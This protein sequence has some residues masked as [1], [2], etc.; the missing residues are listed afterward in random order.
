MTVEVLVSTPRFGTPEF[1]QKKSG[2]KTAS[3][4]AGV[5]PASKPLQTSFFKNDGRKKLKAGDV[6]FSQG[7]PGGDLYFIEEGIV[8]IYQG[9]DTEPVHLSDMKAG[10]II[11]VITCLTREPRMATARAKTSVIC[12]Q[13]PHEAIKKVLQELPNWLKIVVKEFSV[14]LAHMNRLYGETL[15]DLKKAQVEQVDNVYLGALIASAFAHTAEFV[16]VKY[17]E[18]KLVVVDELIQR[19]ELIL[20]LPREKIDRIFGVMVNSGLLRL[21]IEQERKRTVTT[22]DNAKKMAFFAQFIKESK[23]GPTKKLLNVHLTNRDTRVLSGIVKYA[24]KLQMDL[25]KVG[26]LDI[27]DLEN[28]MERVTGVTFEKEA[29]QKG[30][31]LKLVTLEEVGGKESV[32]TRP[33]QLGR[34][35]ACLEAIRRLSTLDTKEDSQT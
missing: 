16:A 13:V 9:S 24:A 34:T 1:L 30:I 31:E 15:K 17:E 7:D 11:G 22:L 4:S 29:I 5:K 28:S 23:S 8:E 32:V 35:I 10:E 33:S 25:N 19:L 6:L 18:T 21:E 20:N 3:S 2:T 14:R 12:K 27:Q 26:R